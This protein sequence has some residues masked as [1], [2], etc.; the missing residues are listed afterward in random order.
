MSRC[1]DLFIA[2]SELSPSER[3]EFLEANC[4]DDPALRTEVERLLET[5]N[6]TADFLE[7]PAVRRPELAQGTQIGPGH[8][9]GRYTISTLLGEGGMGVVWQADQTE[10]VRRTVALKLLKPGMDSQ[11]VIAR[12][13]AERRAL[14]RMDHPNIAKVLDAGTTGDGRPFVVMELVRGL[15]VTKYCD[16]HQ[17]SVLDRIELLIPVCR[18]VQ[19]A[20][21][22]GIIHRDLKPSNI[23]VCQ[24]DGHATPK[25]I[26]F[27]IARSVERTPGEISHTRA[28]VLLGTPA[29][30]SPEQALAGSEVDTRTDVYSLGAVLYE[31]LCGAP[32][33]DPHVLATLPADALLRTIRDDDPPRPS[34]RLVAGERSETM[35]SARSASRASLQR[36]LKGD[37]DRIVMKALE[38]EPSR[39][40]ETAAALADD[41]ERCLRHE[42]VMA[43]Y[44]SAGYVAAKFVRRH[45]AGAVATLLVLG[46]LIVGTIVSSLLMARA[47]DAEQR[48]LTLLNRATLNEQRYRHQA[49][50]SDM[51]LA[52]DAL[53]DDD[54]KRL[55][56]LLDQHVPDEDE[57]DNSFAWHFLQRRCAA[58][59]RIIDRIDD[60]FYFVTFSPDRS[61]LAAASADKRVRFYDAPTFR[62]KRSLFAEQDEVNSV[63]FSPDGKQFVTAGD[64]GTVKF[65]NATTYA[66]LRTIQVFDEKAYQTVFVDVPDGRWIAV[67]GDNS[68]VRLFDAESGE[69]RGPA[70]EHGRT[71]EAIAASADGLLATASHDGIPRIWDVATGRLVRKGPNFGSRLISTT[72]SP[73]G[74]WALFGMVKP[75]FLVWDMTSKANPKAY[76]TNA[77]RRGEGEAAQSIVFLGDSRTIALADRG[78]V[79]RIGTLSAKGVPASEL[80][81]GQHPRWVAH[82]DHIYSMSA[83]PDGRLIVSAGRDGL[84]TASMPFDDRVLPETANSGVFSSL[85]VVSSLAAQGNDTVS[86]ASSEGAFLLNLKRLSLQQIASDPKECEAIVHSDD[87]GLVV[88][89]FPEI[90]LV[91]WQ[92]SGGTYRELWR[93]AIDGTPGIMKLRLSRDRR[94]IAA[95][96]SPNTNEAKQVHLIDAETGRHLNEKSVAGSFGLDFSADGRQLAVGQDSTVLILS[97]PDFKVIKELEGHALSVPAI[98]FSPDGRWL[99][100]GAGDRKAIL[101]ETR[102]WKPLPWIAA[103]G[104][105]R[106]ISFAPD[107]KTLMTAGQDQVPA[108]WDEQTKRL[109]MHLPKVEG[110]F[111]P[112]RFTGS[113]EFIIGP[114]P[115]RG[116]YLFDGRKMKANDAEPINP[117]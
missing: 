35:A 117:R 7:S 61:T 65:W 112:M 97:L 64:D 47:I 83:S 31:L 37:I 3:A 103:G 86:V 28:I 113:G 54:P 85:G 30:V 21:S 24:E 87:A 8:R 63:V 102:T 46:C 95:L 110:S 75:E 17:L 114:H 58:S 33:F 15:V 70:L 60:A 76:P 109:L 22:K 57:T 66:L 36:K 2:A 9:I 77:A 40:Y 52:S 98:C 73:D 107:G 71:V 92:R 16:V 39:R 1:K 50:I 82:H 32:P 34:R 45:R 44:P 111:W 78:G 29:Y 69:P 13:E 91:A 14:E 104:E 89:G 10:P 55:K 19:H 101:W 12:F 38:K 67:S 81:Q 56:E 93:H 18:A 79:I 72:F 90:G 27:G 106:C 25:V 5:L 116:L 11:Q 51:N 42:P 6:E 68:T 59:S 96:V 115:K 4:A 48:A 74:R 100:T 49:F 84:L 108:L 94:F 20:H 88:G 26:D 41:L 53:Y 99:A 23:L 43:A 80:T 62:M 105:V